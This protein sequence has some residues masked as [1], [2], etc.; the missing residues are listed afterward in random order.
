MEI[1]TCWLLDYIAFML[2]QML[3]QHGKWWTYPLRLVAEYCGASGLCHEREELERQSPKP[4]PYL[5]LPAL[6]QVDLTE[7][8]MRLCRGGK[9]PEV[10]PRA[11]RASL[12]SQAEPVGSIY[13]WIPPYS[14]MF[15]KAISTRNKVHELFHQ[16]SSENTCFTKL[17]HFGEGFSLLKHASLD[18]GPVWQAWLKPLL[19]QL[20]TP[21]LLT[22]AGSTETTPQLE[23]PTPPHFPSESCDTLS[24][25][26]GPETGGICSSQFQGRR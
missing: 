24:I 8:T 1:W 2:C 20:R 13:H 14:S 23:A 4:T 7:K 26:A 21:P 11:N 17:Q 3:E 18:L 25:V 16:E 5:T 6:G 15:I 12:A 22:A 19:M 9:T 10:L